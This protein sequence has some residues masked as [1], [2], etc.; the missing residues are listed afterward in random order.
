[1]EW[2]QIPG[3]E[4]Y[5]VSDEG[6]ISYKGG[7]Q[8]GILRTSQ[9]KKGYLFVNLRFP[10]GYG[11]GKTTMY[12]HR[13]V[14]LAFVGPAPI[15]KSHGHHKEPPIT[16]NRLDNLEWYASCNQYIEDDRALEAEAEKYPSS[17][18][19]GENQWPTAE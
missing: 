14:L 10:N 19:E 7:P 3:W 18:E 9:K 15:G 11:T 8:K 16:N 12:V 2:K 13:A 17:E 5:W 6:Q 4:A 1:M